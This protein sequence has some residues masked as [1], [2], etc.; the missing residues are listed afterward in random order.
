MGAEVVPV[1]VNRR[2]AMDDDV[3]LLALTAMTCPVEVTNPAQCARTRYDPG[4]SG[5]SSKRPPLS[6]FAKAVVTPSADTKAPPT[7]APASSR[8]V[9]CIDPAPEMDAV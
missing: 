2:R 9:P 5:P 3:R 4:D 7:G 8:T 1:D 6:A